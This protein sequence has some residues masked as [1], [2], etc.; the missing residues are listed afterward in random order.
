MKSHHESRSL[1]ANTTSL[2]EIAGIDTYFIPITWI[3]NANCPQLFLG[4]YQK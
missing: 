4:L 2:I 1:W 3:T